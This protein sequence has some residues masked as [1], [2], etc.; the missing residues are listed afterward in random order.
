[1]TGASVLSLLEGLSV[2]IVLV[3]FAYM[4]AANE[5]KVVGV[6]LATRRVNGLHAN[7]QIA[8]VDIGEICSVGLLGSP[9]AARTGLAHATSCNDAGATQY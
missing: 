7:I 1:M 3:E 6:I 5:R 4:L 2:A 9:P 8:R